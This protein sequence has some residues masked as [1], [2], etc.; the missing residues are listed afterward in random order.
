MVR[1]WLLGGII[2]AM[3]NHQGNLFAARQIRNLGFTCQVAAVARYPE[4]VEE[5]ASYKVCTAFN[6]YDEAGSGLARHALN[7]RASG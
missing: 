5:L 6:M 2:L 7:G 3:P 4:E 1:F